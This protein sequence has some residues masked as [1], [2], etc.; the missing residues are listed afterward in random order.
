MEDSTFFRSTVGMFRRTS[1]QRPALQFRIAKRIIDKVTAKNEEKKSG[2]IFRAVAFQG[3]QLFNAITVV[4]LQFNGIALD[5][6]PA[7]EFTFH[8]F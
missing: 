8:V 4:P 3:E 5:R 6:A 7:R 1:D 2:N